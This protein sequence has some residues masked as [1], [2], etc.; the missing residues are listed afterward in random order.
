MLPI[1]ILVVQKGLAHGISGNYYSP[2]LST[3]I[4]LS[5][6]QIGL[7]Y[8]AIMA[9]QAVILPLAGWLTDKHGYTLGLILGNAVAGSLLVPFV[10]FRT[11]WAAVAAMLASSTFSTFDGIAFNV[12]VTRLSDPLNRATLF[13]GTEALF[14]LMFV[15]GPLLGGILFANGAALPFIVAALLL[16]TSIVSIGRLRR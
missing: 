13:G 12:A 14:N 6:A 7:S 15:V 4:G 2:Y 8:S 10:A 5:E 9:L 3:S 1:L 11:P 16:V